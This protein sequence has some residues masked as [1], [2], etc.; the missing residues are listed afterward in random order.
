VCCSLRFQRIYREIKV[1]DKDQYLEISAE[2]LREIS[3]QLVDP[4]EF[5][6]AVKI[7]AHLIGTSTVDWAVI[8]SDGTFAFH[9]MEGDWRV[10]F[11]DLPAGVAVRSMTLNGEEL[12]EQTFTITS[13]RGPSLPL[14]ITLQ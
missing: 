12:R 9:V 13:A 11:A 2:P 5:Q 7:S 1:D 3:G 4:P 10:D 6:R 14:R 8:S